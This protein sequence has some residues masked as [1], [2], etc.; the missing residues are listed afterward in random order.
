MNEIKKILLI[1]GTRP[2]AIK[3]APLY[4]EF[5]KS[6]RFDTKICVTAQHREMLDQ[7]LD[8]FEII[9]DYDLNIMKK[10]QSLSDVSSIAMKALQ[11]ILEDEKPDLVIV[12]GDTTTTFMGALSSYYK[13]IPVAHLEA[14]LRSGN[15]YSPFPEEGNRIMT[16]HISKY[17]FAATKTSKTNLV[18]EGIKNNI[19]IVGNTVIDA[20]LLGLNIV[21][22][23]TETYEKYFDFIDFNKKII[24]LTGHRRESFGEP[25]N[26]LC[27]AIKEIS[28]KYTDDVEI[29]YPV[30]LNPNV[31]EPVKKLLGN[32]ANVH[33]IDPLDYPYMI[34]L[35]NKSYLVIT[36]SG[37]IQEEA[38]SL[39]KPILVTR[40]VTER[41]EGVMSGTAKLV[42]TDKEKIIK[43]TI[44]LMEDEN[45]YRKMS[46]IENPYGDGTTSKQILEILLKEMF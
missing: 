11:N 24:L 45:E 23:N 46:S 2:E 41:V 44:L 34:W 36:D 26:N 33:L 22:K 32:L 30:H 5:K 17:H 20:L 18:N 1:F 38:P 15:L 43:E 21:S 16:G 10:G 27:S 29:I 7:V 25:F 14:G 42:G 35:M 19:Y 4:K 12:Q 6:D 8:F 40:E 13:K 31:Q 3:F 9:P 28:K 39:G 37:G